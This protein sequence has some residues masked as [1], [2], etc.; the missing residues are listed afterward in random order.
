MIVST[1]QYSVSTTAVKIVATA[2][3][4]RNVWLH[5]LN[6]AEMFLGPTSAVTASTGFL[7]DKS[8]GIMQLE[9]DPSDELWAIT[10]SGTHTVSVL[11]VTL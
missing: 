11:Q 7:L 5:G 8:A 1:A 9:L 3:V 2:E 10:A 6:S 4:G